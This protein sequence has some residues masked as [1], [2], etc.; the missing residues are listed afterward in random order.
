MFAAWI[1]RLL[2]PR[3]ATIRKPARRN[4]SIGFQ[5][6][7]LEDRSVPAF[8]APAS[9]LAGSNPAGIAVGDFNADGK[10]DMAVAN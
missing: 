7:A 10:A 8:L 5:L 6:E 4:R 9:Y 2:S 3:T 1:G